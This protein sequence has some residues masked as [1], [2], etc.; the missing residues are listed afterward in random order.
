MK[1]NSEVVVE[2][3]AGEGSANRYSA[4]ALE[5]GL[6]I[7]EALSTTTEGVTLNQLAAMLGRN[8]NQIF[9]MVATLHQRGFIQCGADDRYTLTLKLFRLSHRQQPMKQLIE[10]A[11]PLLRE[12]AQRTRQSCHLSVFEQGRVVVVS[13]ADNPDRWT[14]GLKVGAVMGLTDTSSGHVLLAYQDEVTRSRM[15]NSRVRVDGEQDLDP[16]HLFALLEEVRSK[17]CSLMPSIQIQGITNVAQPVRASGARVIAAINIP[18]MARIDKAPGP[19]I[20]EVRHMQTDVCRRLS[21]K[22]GFDEL[23]ADAIV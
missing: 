12:L 3:E 9:R 23:D 1:L 21:I 22:L 19:A 5:K 4:P 14:F 17:G 16:G 18:Y 15:L 6:D 7:L 20:D 10:E 8:V 11:Q 2:A 13:Q